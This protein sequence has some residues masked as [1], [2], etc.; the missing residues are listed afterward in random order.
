MRSSQQQKQNTPPVRALPQQ[1]QARTL[2]SEPDE[3]YAFDSEFELSDPELEPTPAPQPQRSPRR[4]LRASQN[5][6]D[7]LDLDLGES[8][9]LSQIMPSRRTGTQGGKDPRRVPEHH[10][11]IGV[12]L[13]LIA[14][15]KRWHPHA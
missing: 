14:V 11:F 3:D 13:S 15:H 7:S 2:P 12:C 8:V 1:Q 10:V 4:D 6:D 9:R 5:A